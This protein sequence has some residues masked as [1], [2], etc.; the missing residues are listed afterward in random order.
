MTDTTKLDYLI[1]EANLAY[2]TERVEKLNKR[3][4]KLGVA[5]IVVTI[6]SE[7]TETI[8]AKD[9]VTGEVLRIIR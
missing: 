4:R 2:L 7:N 1:P 6:D 3:A 8:E 5:E 9:V